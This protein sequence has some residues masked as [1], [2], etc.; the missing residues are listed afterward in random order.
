M[1]RQYNAAGNLNPVGRGADL[2]LAHQILKLATARRFDAGKAPALAKRYRASVLAAPQNAPSSATS[3]PVVRR[4]GNAI[5]DHML[6]ADGIGIQ[7][8][9]TA[10]Q[11]AAHHDGTWSD[12]FRIEHHNVSDCAQFDPAASFE[13]EG[14]GLRTRQKA[15]RLFQRQ[16]PTLSYPFA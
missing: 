16:Q 13:P 3:W 8:C 14:I 6:Y 1:A 10:R 12:G 7:P 15:H 5:D 9:L 4:D 2:A 11:I